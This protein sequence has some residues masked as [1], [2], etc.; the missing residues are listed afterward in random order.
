M[1]V[2][3]ATVEPA[4]DGED[5]DETGEDG[6]PTALLLQLGELMRSRGRQPG[7]LNQ[8]SAAWRAH[9]PIAP[10]RIDAKASSY[11]LRAPQSVAACSYT[12]A[13]KD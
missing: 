1:F 5:C 3:E 8:W 11:P 4:A 2:M 12:G 9:G 7:Q 10:L 6:P 13:G